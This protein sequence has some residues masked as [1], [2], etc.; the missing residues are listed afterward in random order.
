MRVK[1]KKWKFRG[2]PLL[3]LL[4]SQFNRQTVIRLYPFVYTTLY[5]RTSGQKTVR[6]ICLEASRMCVARHHHLITN[7][8]LQ[9]PCVVIWVMLHSPELV[10]FIHQNP[11]SGLHYTSFNTQVRTVSAHWISLVSSSCLIS[12][13]IKIKNVNLASN[14]IMSITVFHFTTRSSSKTSDRV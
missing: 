8:E 13:Y 1:K 9:P 6:I 11:P 7:S 4:I 2:T 14:S 3:P 12:T 10:E 5:S